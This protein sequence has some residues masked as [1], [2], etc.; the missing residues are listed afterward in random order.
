MQKMCH[1]FY[2]GS[3]GDDGVNILHIYY[4]E[5]FDMWYFTYMSTPEEA[6]HEIAYL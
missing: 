5:D 6:L 2:G 1:G 4:V 3:G